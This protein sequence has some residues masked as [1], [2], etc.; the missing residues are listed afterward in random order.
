MT[1]AVALS[2]KPL[3]IQSG[4]KLATWP[5]ASTR[6]RARRTAAATSWPS[7]WRR[8][9]HLAQRCAREPLIPERSACAF[10]VT[11]T[12]YS[13]AVELVVAGVLLAPAINM[14]R[15]QQ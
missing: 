13:A 9:M 7:A 12:G 15:L 3:K 11:I 4:V 6:A 5:R 2:A 8:R 1:L 10:S 14:P